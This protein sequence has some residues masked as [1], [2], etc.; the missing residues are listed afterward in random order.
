MNLNKFE[1][2]KIFLRAPAIK[3]LG[4]SVLTLTLSLPVANTDSLEEDIMTQTSSYQVSSTLGRANGP[5]LLS[6]G[7]PLPLRPQPHHTTCLLMPMSLPGCAS[8]P[9]SLLSFSAAILRGVPGTVGSFP[10][11]S[12]LF[13]TNVN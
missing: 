2:A 8:P 7:N 12:L 4:G 13:N 10:G 1:A 11:T 9:L 5:A 3:G 6:L